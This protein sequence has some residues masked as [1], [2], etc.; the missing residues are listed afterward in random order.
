LFV[1]LQD[2]EIN[3]L[4]DADLSKVEQDHSYV[5]VYEDLIDSSNATPVSTT[6]LDN[7]VYFKSA[8]EHAIGPG[9]SVNYNLYYGRDYIKYIKPTSYYNYDIDE[10][11]YSYIQ[12]D[13]STI[14]YYLTG[15][16]SQDNAILSATPSDVNLYQDVVNKNS[17]EN[18]TLT[19]FNDGVDWVDNKSTKAETKVIGNFNGPK[20]KL[21][22]N[23]GPDY[24]MFKYRIST[25]SNS[26][27]QIEQV[28]VDWTGV[29]CYSSSG[30]LESELLDISNLGYEEYI[31]EIETLYDKNVLSYGNNIL[32]KEIQFLKNYNIS[33]GEEL[34]NPDLSFISIGGVK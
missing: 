24:G 22:G 34:I 16:N 11:V 32:I 33:L 6:V 20:F 17:S 15:N 29:D 26:N 19:F 23:I 21:I 12:Y 9:N 28:V 31:I 7:I 13:Q 18:Y 10:T 2:N 3:Y 4:Y 1:D 14:S 8:K 25:K 30:L 5:M 27:Q